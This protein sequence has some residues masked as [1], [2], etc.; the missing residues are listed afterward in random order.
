[1]KTEQQQ[2]YLQQGVRRAKR[3]VKTMMARPRVKHPIPPFQ[4]W[5][6][7]LSS[8]FFICSTSL[9]ISGIHSPSKIWKWRWI[10]IDILVSIHSFKSYQTPFRLDAVKKD[11]SNNFLIHFPAMSEVVELVQGVDG[12]VGDGLRVGGYLEASNEPPICE[13]WHQDHQRP[14]DG[15]HCP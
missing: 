7:T 13:Q 3:T 6:N 5:G 14:S 11:S 8:R 15:H 4:A 10:E 9:S 2:Q 12:Q 1:M